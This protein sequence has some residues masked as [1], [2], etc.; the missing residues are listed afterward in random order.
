[1]TPEEERQ[2]ARQRVQEWC[3]AILLGAFII[4]GNVLTFYKG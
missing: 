2:Q 4:A 1:M 3:A